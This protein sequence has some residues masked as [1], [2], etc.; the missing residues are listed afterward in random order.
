[1]TDKFRILPK[2]ESFWDILV[3]NDLYVGSKNLC[4][5][6]R[7][8]FLVVSRLQKPIFDEGEFFLSVQLVDDVS[9]I[10]QRHT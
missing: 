6:S 1:M 3:D 5:F 4:V 7:V 9:C 2:F 10:S 8:F